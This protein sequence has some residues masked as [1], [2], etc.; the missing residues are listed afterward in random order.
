MRSFIALTVLGLAG[1]AV[2]V[3]VVPVLLVDG[4]GASPTLAIVQHAVLVALAA[5]AGTSL[6]PIANLRSHVAG[7]GSRWCG[8]EVGAAL[9]IGVGI[10]ALDV[11]A[12]LLLLPGLDHAA[13]PSATVALWP[14]AL[15]ALSVCDEILWRWGALSVVLSVLLA[16]RRRH[17]PAI[18]GERL[19]AAAI[20]AVIVVAAHATRDGSDRMW[21][22]QALTAGLPALA[23]GWLCARWSLEAAMIAHVVQHLLAA[24]AIVGGFAIAG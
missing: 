15:A 12:G 21:L 6:A 24:L 9:L 19:F 23:Y 2:A 11:V 17:G 22:A 3:A 18:L 7:I 1:L 8:P 13:R 14:L 5:L 10:A 4:P 16:I 20:V